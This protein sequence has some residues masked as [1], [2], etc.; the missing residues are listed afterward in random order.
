MPAVASLQATRS[1]RFLRIEVADQGPGVSPDVLPHLFDRFYKTDAS[2]QGG[3]GLGLAIAT[4]HANRLGGDLTVRPGFPR[5]LVFT[6]QLP[7]TVSLRSGDVA[8]KS[9]LQAD[10]EEPDFTRRTP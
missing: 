10:G 8:E 3:S 6:L 2:R 4:Q 7:V 5:G 9:V 1:P